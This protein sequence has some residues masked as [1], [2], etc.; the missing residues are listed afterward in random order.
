VYQFTPDKQISFDNRIY[1]IIYL[2]HQH[3]GLQCPWSQAQITVEQNPISSMLHIIIESSGDSM[4][5]SRSSSVYFI[6]GKS[7]FQFHI[8]HTLNLSQIKP[9]F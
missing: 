6:I 2:Q 7:E 8:L 1:N 5:G 4:N 9:R 3:A